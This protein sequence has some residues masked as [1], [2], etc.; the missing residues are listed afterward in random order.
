LLPAGLRQLRVVVGDVEPLRL[1]I[2]VGVDQLVRKVLLRGVLAHLDAGSSN[3]SGV[4]G[5]RLGLQSENFRKSTQWGLIPK[6]A[7]QKWTK[8][9][10]WKIP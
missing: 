9:E 4:V 5:T 10:V 7:S 2:L 8:T 3:Y 6:K 1:P